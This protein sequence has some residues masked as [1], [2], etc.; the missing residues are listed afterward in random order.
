MIKV[1]SK[2][3]MFIVT[4][5]ENGISIRYPKVVFLRDN[6]LYK[7]KNEFYHTFY[8]FFFPALIN[9]YF[10]PQPSRINPHSINFPIQ[11]ILQS[12]FIK[13]KLKFMSIY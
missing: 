12:L 3:E 11:S 5:S 2:K 6:N 4:N 13:H 8:S 7:Y 1:T 9:Q 10:L